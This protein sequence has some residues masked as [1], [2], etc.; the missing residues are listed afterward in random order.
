MGKQATAVAEATNTFLFNLDWKRKEVRGRLVVVV[1]EIELVLC[2][3]E[4]RR[5]QGM[6]R[7]FLSMPFCQFLNDS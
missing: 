4:E 3:C 7:V 5:R 6:V 2:F 1:V